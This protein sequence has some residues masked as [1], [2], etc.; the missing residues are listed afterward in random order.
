M[1]YITLRP[2]LQTN[3]TSTGG[4]VQVQLGHV[5]AFLIVL[6]LMAF[7]SAAVGPTVVPQ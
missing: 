1:C 3:E 5:P 4:F 6:L 2:A 7:V